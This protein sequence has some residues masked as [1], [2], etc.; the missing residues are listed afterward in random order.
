MAAMIGQPPFQYADPRLTPWPPEARP[1][2]QHDPPQ[3]RHF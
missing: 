2:S 3:H 1:S